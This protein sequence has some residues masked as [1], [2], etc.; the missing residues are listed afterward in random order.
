MCSWIQ[1]GNTVVLLTISRECFITNILHIISHT[2]THI[3]S[4]H[5]FYSYILQRLN[6]NPYASSVT[7][8]AANDGSVIVNT[9]NYLPDIYQG[10]NVSVQAQCEF[11]ELHLPNLL[12]K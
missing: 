11:S 3:Q 2:H 8:L 12:I 10:W 1:L 5:A 4:L 7:L 6:I 9:T